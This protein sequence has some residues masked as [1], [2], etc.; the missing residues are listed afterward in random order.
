M[1]EDGDSTTSPNN[2]KVKKQNGLIF[3]SNVKAQPYFQGI[4]YFFPICA[5]QSCRDGCA[6][7]LLELIF[8]WVVLMLIT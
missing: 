6:K 7:Y 8:A 4:K 2:Q 5:F 3:R 1:S